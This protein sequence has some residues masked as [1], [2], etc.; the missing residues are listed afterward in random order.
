VVTYLSAIY[1]LT[2]GGNGAHV[3]ISVQTNTLPRLEL[4]AVA[5]AP[6]LYVA[7][8]PITFY[9]EPGEVP[10]V[11]LVAQ[12]IGFGNTN[13]VTLVGYLVPLG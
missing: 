3:N 4:P 2:A 12:F 1:A 10:S 11:N 6:T 5:I 7:S 8:G 9:F 13:T